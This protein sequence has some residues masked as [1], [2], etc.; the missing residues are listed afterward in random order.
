MV[1]SNRLR[2]HA[3]LQLMDSNILRHAQLQLIDVWWMTRI[4]VRFEDVQ[5]PPMQ[6][7]AAQLLPIHNLNV[8]HTYGSRECHVFI[9]LGGKRFPFFKM[10]LASGSF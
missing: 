10:V 4:M 8:Y 2:Q 3:R 1:D 7:H 9:S 6:S 5:L